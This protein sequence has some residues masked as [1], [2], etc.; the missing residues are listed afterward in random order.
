MADLEG[1]H[2][3]VTDSILTQ[4]NTISFNLIKEGCGKSTPYAELTQNNTQN[5]VSDI[6][7]LREHFGI[8]KWHVFGGSWGSTLSLIYAQNHPD[9][10]LSL[11]LRG[12]FM[13]RKVNCTGS[14][15]RAQ[16]MSS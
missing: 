11:T 12:I 15:N 7:A 9:K 6:E 5:S 13:C 8:D 16:A 2:N 1:V 3:L 10:A 14:T 4:Q